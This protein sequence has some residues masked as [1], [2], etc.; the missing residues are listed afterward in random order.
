MWCTSC[1][2]VQTQHL[3]PLGSCR[4]WTTTPLPVNWTQHRRKG[5]HFTSLLCFT[6][7]Q[8]LLKTFDIVVPSVRTS[9]LYLDRCCFGD[10]PQ[11]DNA[12]F[13]IWTHPLSFFIYLYHWWGW[14][15]Q[16]AFKS[17]H[18]NNMYADYLTHTYISTHP[19]WAPC[20]WWG[21]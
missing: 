3:S 12:T 15:T 4:F 1:C 19:G 18:L 6:Y 7:N 10:L 20:Q 2:C 9:S 5:C 16:E 14:G 11:Y 8:I 21:P 17:Q 13:V